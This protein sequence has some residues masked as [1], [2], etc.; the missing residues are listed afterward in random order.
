MARLDAV[1]YVVWIV[2]EA[3]PEIFLLPA[4]VVSV[5]WL[6]PSVEAPKVVA[7]AA[8]VFGSPAFHLSGMPLNRLG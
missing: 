8:A 2:A 1:Y 6:V 4:V 7:P 3:A 5:A